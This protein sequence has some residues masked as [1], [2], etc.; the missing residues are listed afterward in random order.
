MLI[1]M[2]DYLLKRGAYPMEQTMGLREIIHLVKKR[3]VMIICITVACTAL[4]G[5]LSFYVLKPVYEA[6]TSIIVSKPTADTIAQT[7]NDVL[8]YQN[9]VKTYS[10]I[11]SSKSVAKAAAEKINNKYTALQIQKATDVSPQTSTQI[12]TISVRSGNA[13][14]ALDIVGAISESFIAES[15]AVFPNGGVIKVMD[16]PELPEIPVKPNKSLNI[17]IGFFLGLVAAGSLAFLLEYMDKTIKS[18]ED[19]VKYLLDVPVI[20]IIPKEAK[21]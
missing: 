8:M 11:A 3:I 2:K 7:Y 9:L 10:E 17:A 21:R 15:A 16:E 4:A 14:D 20:G 18:E 12:L 1:Y 19:V 13:Q 5:G 6:K